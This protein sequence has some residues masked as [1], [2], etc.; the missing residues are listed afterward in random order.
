MA[1][2]EKN[3]QSVNYKILKTADVQIFQLL[4]HAQCTIVKDEIE[5]SKTVGTLCQK[6]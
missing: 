3:G 4:S 6:V 1:P 5:T 2:E